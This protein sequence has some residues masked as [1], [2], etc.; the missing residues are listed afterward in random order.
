MLNIV[1]DAEFTIVLPQRPS[2]DPS[3]SS[4]WLSCIR[5]IRVQIQ[6]KHIG[7]FRHQGQLFWLFL[8]FEKRIIII[9][10]TM[11]PHPHQIQCEENVCCYQYFK[12]QHLHILASEEWELQTRYVRFKYKAFTNHKITACFVFFSLNYQLNKK[13]HVC[14]SCPLHSLSSTSE[15]CTTYCFKQKQAMSSE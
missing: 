11:L 12:S 9:L 7:N 6:L 14:L 1:T 4:L 10:V 3:C 8:F 13:S 2:R 15:T 5:K